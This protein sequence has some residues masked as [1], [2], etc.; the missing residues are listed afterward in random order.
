[1]VSTLAETAELV[2]SPL[3]EITRAMPETTALPAPTTVSDS[4]APSLPS[5]QTPAASPSLLTP[6]SAATITNSAPIPT[7]SGPTPTTAPNLPTIMPSP[8]PPTAVPPA[9]AVALNLPGEV[10]NG[11]LRVVAVTRP[12]DALIRELGGSAPNAPSEQAWVLIEMLLVCTGSQNCAPNTTSL[13]LVGSSGRS[14]VPAADFYL[15]PLFGPGAYSLGQVWGYSGFV[16]PTSEAQLYLLLN[17]TGQTY[18]FALQ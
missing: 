6:V 2:S 8:V 16:V 14:Y 1:M 13:S 4:P 15:E 3:L 17:Q 5:P 11:Q 12:A 18:A 10:G 7:N 9:N